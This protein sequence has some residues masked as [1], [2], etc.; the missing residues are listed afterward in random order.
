MSST[1][2]VNDFWSVIGCVLIM[3]SIVIFYSTTERNLHNYYNKYKVIKSF[4]RDKKYYVQVCILKI[5]WI[6]PIYKTYEYVQKTNFGEKRHTLY[7]SDYNDAVTE[8]K[9]QYLVDKWSK[10][11][12]KKGKK[13]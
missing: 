5:F 13:K 4:K 7:F 10:Q 3:F 12:K 9:Q 2:S 6:I 1:F 11:N 8:I